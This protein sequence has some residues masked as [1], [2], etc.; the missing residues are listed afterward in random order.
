MTTPP[1]SATLFLRLKSGVS[2]RVLFAKIRFV[3]VLIVATSFWD[4]TPRKS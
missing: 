1:A 2:P 4:A 3:V